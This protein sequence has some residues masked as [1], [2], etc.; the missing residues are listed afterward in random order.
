MSQSEAKQKIQRLID[1]FKN[2]TPVEFNSYNE[3]N[4]RKDFILPLFRALGWDI[5][6]EIENNEV[7]E[8]E[9]NIAGRVDYSFKLAG[10]TQFLLEAKSI[11]ENLEKDQWAKQAIEYGWNKGIPW[12]VLTDFEGLKIFN[13]D[14]KTKDLRPCLDL[15]YSDYI[16]KFDR[17]WLLSRES[18]QTNAL[19]KLL[20]EF[21]ISAK[22][23]K[24][25]DKLA[26]DLVKWRYQLTHNFELWNKNMKLSPEDL[27]ESIQRI[28]DRL[29]FIRVA[30]DRQIEEK[31]LWQTYQKWVQG[32]QKTQN[33]IKVLVPLFRKF[34]E[35]YDSN[36][37]QEHLCEKLETEGEPFRKIIP[38]MYA[39]KEE[40]VKYRFDAIDVDVLGNVYEQY[41]GIV[42]GQIADSKKRKEGIYYTPS[43]IVNYLTKNTLGPLLAQSSSIQNLKKIRIVDPACG[44]GSFLIKT[45]E[46]IN[47][48]YKK[49]DHTVDKSIKLSILTE[50]IYGVDLDPQAVEIARLNLLLSSLSKKTKLPLLAKNIVRGNSLISGSNKELSKYFGTEISD[51]HPFEWNYEFE[52]VYRDNKGFDIVIGNPPYLSYYSKFSQKPKDNEIKYFV[53][54]Y[55]LW[56]KHNL[57]PRINSIMLFIYKALELLKKGGRCGFVINGDFLTIKA[58]KEIRKYLLEN[59]EIELIVESAPFPN[60][61][62]DVSLIVITKN[63]YTEPVNLHKLK[64]VTSIDEAGVENGAKSCLQEIFLKNQDYMFSVPLQ[65]EL[66][67][68]I[69]EKSILLTKISRVTTGM[70]TTLDDF[71][72]DEKKNEFWHPGLFGSN[73]NMFSILWPNEDQLEHTRGRMRYV[74]F[75]PK[76]EARVN[77]QLADS[78]SKTV[79][80]IGSESRF[81]EPKILVRQGPGS[82]EVVAAIDIEGQYYA[83]QTLHL[84]N[85]RDTNYGLWYILAILN[86]KLISYYAREKKIIKFGPKKPPQI[87]VADL[88]RLPIGLLSDENKIIITDL[89]RIA[90]EQSSIMERI[91]T[92][93][94][95]DENKQ[96][97]DVY[98]R[99]MNKLNELVY[100]LYNLSQEEK[101]IVEKNVYK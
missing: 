78:G 24:V 50:N 41:L 75:D 3:A 88:K 31:M 18:F 98:K 27:N 69:E 52:N 23:I 62:V 66:I 53:D 4:T 39:D 57:K 25:G 35:T 33:F 93:P 8:E 99:N 45:L 68:K 64:W 96:Y 86:S 21:G 14:W 2:L 48:K 37:F 20:S 85:Q 67:D 5:S 92:I 60:V 72:S 22:R 15:K 12:V 51:Y 95:T 47:D 28:L 56:D 19:D 43:Y 91:Q 16:S 94:N 40:G 38:D 29:I 34:D 83:H 59:C 44:S 54:K 17:L 58:F 87:R 82:R 101:A 49:I 61:N 84:I 46:V 63:D 80:V 42:Q 65:K 77:Q 30:E 73:V 97:I 1:R 7:N 9:P 11:S 81:K 79:K 89:E 55:P 36:L 76:V 90:K 70:V 13:S 10:I 74:C 71:W 26:E 100:A 32:D 6:N